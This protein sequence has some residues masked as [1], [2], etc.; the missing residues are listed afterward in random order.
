MTG[1]NWLRLS[2]GS[3][4]SLNVDVADASAGVTD[5]WLFLGDSITAR[6][7]THAT[8][9]NVRSIADLISASTSGTRYP[10]EEN[11]GLPC[12]HASDVTGYI[13]S[14]LAMFP[15]KYVTLNLGTNDLWNGGGDVNAYYND[16]QTLANKV[17]AAGKIPVIPHIPWPN[18]GGS[19]DT[20]VQAGNA[21][22]D[23][24]IASNP[25]IVKGPDL[26][27]AFKNHPEYFGSTGDVHPNAAGIAVARQQWAA[28]MMTNVY[29]NYKP[30][31]TGSSPA[32]SAEAENGAVS[33]NGPVTVGTDAS[34]SAGKYIEF[35]PAQ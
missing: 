34:A 33:G 4:V 2:V 13:D 16:M 5:D 18:N 3:G 15:G 19:W 8:S 29:A 17:I 30:G 14:L 35:T 12:V 9:N 24:L 23:Q 27:T 10:I 21:K 1:Y 26:Y 22:I 25:K 20:I 6:Y 28:A 7:A 31:S 11:A 32:V